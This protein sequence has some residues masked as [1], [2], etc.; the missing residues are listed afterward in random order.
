MSFIILLLE[1]ISWVVART[2]FMIRGRSTSLSFFFFFFASVLP[3]PHSSNTR[4]RTVSFS[5]QFATCH[6]SRQCVI[7]N[8]PCGERSSNSIK[9]E[10]YWSSL[11]NPRRTGRD[12][13]APAEA[14]SALRAT[15]DQH[16]FFSGW[17]LYRRALSSAGKNTKG[18]HACQQH[19]NLFPWQRQSL[20]LRVISVTEADIRWAIITFFFPL[21]LPSAALS[22]TFSC[23]P[24]S[25][26]VLLLPLSFS[27]SSVSSSLSFSCLW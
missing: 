20:N 11:W 1:Y 25:C 6:I 21:H 13:A 23:L 7:L 27:S 8:R 14:M 18:P 16:L 17:H 5:T 19:K 26:L 4:R 2:E 10:T 12:N 3:V 22:S 15:D 24:L 9:T